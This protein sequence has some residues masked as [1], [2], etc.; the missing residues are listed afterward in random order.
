MSEW[1]FY[2][3]LAAWW[4]LI[5]PVDDYREEANYVLDL[6]VD[7]PQRKRTLLE[8]GS[9]GGHNASYMRDRFELT[10]VDLSEDMLAV[11]QALNPGVEHICGDMRSIRLGRQFDAVVIHDAIDYMTNEVDLGAAL[12][13]AFVHLCPGGRA[14]FV[15]DATREIFEP[16]HDCGGSDGDDGRS[17]RFMEWTTDPDPA[18][19]VA[20]TDYVF[21]LRHADGRLEVA[22]ETHRTGLFPRS[23]WLR[24]LGE[25]GFDA[26]HL[27]ETTTEQRTPRDVFVGIR[28]GDRP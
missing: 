4:P 18:G 26:H 6:L 11:S 19:T 20:A 15:P 12:T 2:G 28:A 8:L 25:V 27:I 22:H 5:S 13:S 17:V 3:S 23:T 7:T 9:G 1:L 14:V 10:L 16:G 24:I 21:L